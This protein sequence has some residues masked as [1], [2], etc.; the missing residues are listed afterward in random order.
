MSTTKYY[1]DNIS[2]VLANSFFGFT[3]WIVG[4][5]SKTDYLRQGYFLNVRWYRD[6]KGNRKQTKI[7]VDTPVLEKIER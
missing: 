7:E 5:I 6:E 1:A 2:N 3:T 4:Y